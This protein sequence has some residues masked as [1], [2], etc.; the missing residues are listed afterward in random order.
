M[1]GSRAPVR[2]HSHRRATRKTDF[3]E[4]GTSEVRGYS[5][6][7]RSYALEPPQQA[8]I[9]LPHGIS[10]RSPAYKCLPYERGHNTSSAYYHN[11]MYVELRI[12]DALHKKPCRIGSGLC[13]TSENGV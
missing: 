7:P 5:A 1:P 10:T 13:G 11:L 4:R 9:L 6:Y 3:R 8:H 12:S 2:P